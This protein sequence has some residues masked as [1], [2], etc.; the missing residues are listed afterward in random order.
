MM[1]VNIEEIDRARQLLGQG[2]NGRNRRQGVK[3]LVRQRLGRTVA[4][5][6]FHAV[7]KV[8]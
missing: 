2:L 6:L 1:P 8:G 3:C 4:K 7:E 5:R